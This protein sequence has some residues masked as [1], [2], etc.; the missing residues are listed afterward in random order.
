MYGYSV[1][2]NSVHSDLYHQLLDMCMHMD[3]SLEGLHTETGP[4][5]LEAAIMYDEAL[6]SRLR[7]LKL[8]PKSWRRK[9]I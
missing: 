8:S 5:V 9:M 6:I 7:Y 4:G 1:I 3:M 2:R